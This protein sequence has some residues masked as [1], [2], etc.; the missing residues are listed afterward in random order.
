MRTLENIELQ[1]FYTNLQEEVKSL[2]IS[3]EDGATPEEVFTDLALSLLAESGET[4]NYRL[5]YD[6]KVS[7]RGIEHKINAYALSENHETLDLFIT[8]YNG[9]DKIQVVSKPDADKAF[10]RLLKFFKI[11]AYK[12]YVSMIEP[13]SEIF[14]L[15]HTIANAP[16]IKEF[17]TRINILLITDG[18]VKAEFKNS[19]KI[20]DYTIYYRVI[21]INYLFNL[22]EKSR[23]PI[24]ID[25]EANG[26]SLPCIIANNQNEEYQSYL[27]IM[28]GE[29]LA[30]I[31]EQFGSRLLEQNVRSFLQFTGKINKGI[32]KTINEEPHMFLAYNNGI[33]ATAEEVK[34]STLPNGKGNA[35]SFVKDLQIVN[36]GQTT[37]SI[38]HTW[39]KDNAVISEIFV[40]VKL[41]VIKKK[42]KFSQIVTK[43]S[44]CANTQN[45]VSFSDLTANNPFYIEMEKLSRLIYAPHV[46]GNSVQ[47]RWFFERARGQYK[48]ERLRDGRSLSKIRA[49][50]AQNPR[51]Q[52]FTKED[53]AKYINSYGELTKSN[54]VVIGPHIVCRGSQKNHKVYVDHNLPIEVDNVYYE[55][56][57]AKAIIFRTAEKKYGIKPD[58]IGDMRFITVPYTIAYLVYC[59][60]VPID[61]YKIWK[62]QSVSES[63][64]IMLRELMFKIENLIKTR[65]PGSLY[66]EWAKKEDCWIELKNSKIG[67]DIALLENELT[68]PKQIVVRRKI[69]KSHFDF[70][71]EEYQYEK[72][73]N[74]SVE[75]W[76]TIKEW[77]KQTGLLN[78][79]QLDRIFNYLQNLSSNE[80]FTN[81]DRFSLEEILEIVFKKNPELL[82]T[83]D[84][85]IETK[86]DLELLVERAIKM[87][88]W[89]KENKHKM[90]S[91]HFTFL[92][93]I[94]KGKI[95]YS[96]E[97]KTTLTAIEKYLEQYGYIK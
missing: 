97:A 49:F 61:L 96:I 80:S 2:L 30:R 85:N 73:K 31:Y 94:Q 42:D 65:A 33:A 27:S 15:A 41:S 55:D 32:R 40:P 75:T 89:I 4:E 62:D 81:E 78:L 71:E 46:A 60:K 17:L 54:K 58:A 50:D 76:N 26:D 44:E 22:S 56:A 66:G 77:G 51:K 43:I 14:D 69:N 12:D 84:A 8:I 91:D 5:R 34:I 79:S 52:L 90:A 13:S 86:S 57:I 83:Y 35:I 74:I 3:T 1:L 25:F 45:K 72:I 6:E 11:T 9:T 7:K 10:E 47:T 28:P 19:E 48:N 93:D 82:K 23:V 18:E 95:I 87:I 29:V 24:E 21:D 67:F 70:M 37:A 64:G 36:G 68:D 38:Y 88:E 16:E 20:S 63:F 39:K 59:L 53:L 92:K